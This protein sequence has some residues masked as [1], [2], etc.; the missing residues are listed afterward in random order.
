MPP[1]SPAPVPRP[2]AS[3]RRNP[4]GASPPHSSAYRRGI[5]RSVPTLF[6]AL[7]PTA[8][9]RAAFA[10][11]GPPILYLNTPTSKQTLSK[12]LLA[13]FLIMQYN[14]YEVNKGRTCGTSTPPRPYAGD[15]TT[16]TIAVCYASPYYIGIATFLQEVVLGVCV[17]I[18]GVGLLY[19]APFLFA[20]TGANVRGGWDAPRPQGRPVE[21]T[22]RRI[23]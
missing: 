13:L 23:V 20:S 8:N 2:Q 10:R 3:E 19:P 12:K 16:N 9:N 4:H 15:Q 11:G 6:P 14:T 18:C 17:F 5:A 21:K 7:H 22:F 1:G